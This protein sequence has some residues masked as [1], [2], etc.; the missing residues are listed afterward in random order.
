[1]NLDLLLNEI[2]LEAPS[3][4]KDLSE[5]D[6]AFFELE[7][8]VNDRV[9]TDTGRRD[10]TLK[11]TVPSWSD[12]EKKAYDL[13]TRAH[14]LRVAMFLLRALVQTQGLPGLC[15]GFNLLQSHMERFWDTVYPQLDH[16][17][18]DPARMRISV[19]ED[20]DSRD[21]LVGPL[22]ETTLCASREVGKFSLRDYY[23]AT[24]EIVLTEEQKKKLTAAGKQ[25]PGLLQI[26]AAF[27]K[28]DLQDL[29]AN[30]AATAS[31]LESLNHI[32]QLLNEKV[33]FEAAPTFGELSRLL[34]EMDALL[35]K[36]LNRRGVTVSSTQESAIEA[37]EPGAA[38][39]NQLGQMVSSQTDASV[40]TIRNRRDVARILGQICQ[41]YEQNE[42]ASPVP[43]LLKRA[44]RL[45]EKNF[46]EIME[47]LAPDSLAKI[48]FLSGSETDQG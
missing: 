35:V 46:M 21:T 11:G 5:N 24:G 29:Q 16:A 44:M 36:Q 12:I 40:E 10:K 6:P 47:D 3:G 28:C 32:R 42:P 8:M 26:E 22:T 39:E 34:K 4:A 18:S 45:V 17:E 9:E 27:E 13:C 23:L 1:M 41:Y 30:Q 48:Q 7:K 31:S 19:L 15:D 14:D 37:E 38:G 20:L 33:G 2:S 25:V 43:L